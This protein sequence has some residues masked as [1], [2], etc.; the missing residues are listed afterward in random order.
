M[1]AEIWLMTRWSDEQAF[2]AWHH[3]HDFHASHKGIP[4]GLK[5]VRGSAGV[6]LFD[7]FAS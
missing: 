3:G 4:K 7:V 5:L 2:R 6:R 1:P